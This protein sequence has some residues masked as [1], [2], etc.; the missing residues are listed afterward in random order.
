MRSSARHAY[1]FIAFPMAV[2]FVFSLIPTVMGL[3]LSFCAW[4]GSSNLRFIGLTNFRSLAGDAKFGPALTNTLV[5]VVASVP[6]S[7]FLGLLLAVALH[8][9]GQ[10]DESMRRLQEAVRRWPYDRDML[11]ALTSFQLESGRRQ[12]AQATAR[13][14]QAAYPADPQVQVLAA[15]ALGEQPR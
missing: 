3:V 14:L 15:Q 7:I 11:M 9:T 12:D 5:F 4:D 1:L 13:R 2:L 10:V 6:P 8:S